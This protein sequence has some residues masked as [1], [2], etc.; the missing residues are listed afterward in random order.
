MDW[1]LLAPEFVLVGWAA[2]V[3]HLDLFW[4]RL[5]KDQLAYVA[6]TGA[7]VSSLVSLIWIN[8]NSAFGNILQVDNYTTFFRVFFGLIG[9]FAI[10]A[11]ARYVKDRLNHAGE[12]YALILL[13]IIGATYMAAAKELLT[14]Y[15]SL[16]LLSFSLYVLASFAKFDLKS[17]EA[18]IKYMLL[19]AFS[20]AIFL[21]RKSVV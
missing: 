5:R 12:Y 16:E 17:N 8:D 19:G 11:S 3:V 4:G 14:A 15:I 20:S 21:D 7:L 9:F 1:S 10:L 2:M 6:A 13:T 18:G